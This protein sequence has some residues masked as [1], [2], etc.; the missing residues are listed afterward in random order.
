MDINTLRF[1]TKRLEKNSSIVLKTKGECFEVQQ[2]LNEALLNTAK[3]SV[4]TS[5]ARQS[6]ELVSIKQLGK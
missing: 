2:T 3:L 1:R 4:T 6:Q 5:K